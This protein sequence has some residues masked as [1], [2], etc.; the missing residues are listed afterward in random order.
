VIPW[1][2]SLRRQGETETAKGLIVVATVT[3]MVQI[4]CYGLLFEELFSKTR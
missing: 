4:P 3:F 1:V 2:V